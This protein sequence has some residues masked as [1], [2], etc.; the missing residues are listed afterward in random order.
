MN[1]LLQVVNHN[2]NF[3]EAKEEAERLTGLKLPSLD[4]YTDNGYTMN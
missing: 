4:S 3:K 1:D 2:Q